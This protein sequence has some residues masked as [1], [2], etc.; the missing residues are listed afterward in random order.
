M[1]ETKE[2]IMIIP[3]EKILPNRFQPRIKFSEES[4]LNLADSIKEHGI[5]QP[6]IVRSIGDKY[7]IVAGERRYKATVLSGLKEIPALL[8]DINDKDSAEVALI[9]NVQRKDLSPIEEAISYKKILDMGYLTQSDLASKI[10]V[11]QS[12]VANK[13][14]L[15]NLCDDVQE[16]LLDEKISERHARS[17]LKINNEEVQAKFLKRILSKKLT[18]RALDD[19]IAFYIKNNKFKENEEIKN[20]SENNSSP[21]I[22]IK[23]TEEKISSSDKI[24]KIKE[25]LLE[26]NK[27]DNIEQKN[28]NKIDIK[29]DDKNS[30]FEDISIESF[31]DE[32]D[33]IDEK[34]EDDSNMNNN[35][36]NMNED[37]NYN[38]LKSSNGTQGKF[39]MTTD[40]EEEKPQEENSIF[41]FDN[42]NSG[43]NIFSDLMAPQGSKNLFRPGTTQ[44]SVIPTSTEQPQNDATPTNST[45]NVSSMFENLMGVSTTSTEEIDKDT[46]NKFMDPAYVDGEQ[47][48]LSSGN[49]DVNSNVFAKFLQT[50]DEPNKEEVSNSSESNNIFKNLLKKSNDTEEQNN[51]VVSEEKKEEPSNN[52][53]IFSNMFGLNKSE[54]KKEDVKTDNPTQE[55]ASVETESDPKPV[56]S[57]FEPQSLISTDEPKEE[58]KEESTVEEQGQEISTGDI[59][60]NTSNE[61]KPD[62][63]APMK[64]ESTN[65]I[66]L[67][68]SLADFKP[69]SSSTISETSVTPISNDLSSLSPMP[70]SIDT[71]KEESE[72]TEEPDSLNKSLTP[73]D[74]VE[75][76]E[77]KVEDKEEKEQETSEEELI[78]FNTTKPIFVTASSDNQVSSMPTSPII[79]V[80]EEQEEEEEVE[81][82]EQAPVV[83]NIDIED[84]EEEVAEDINNMIGNQPIIV[85]DYDKQYDPV[86]PD[87]AKEV[88]KI[89]FK[90]ILGL[91]R[92]LSETIE[93]CGYEIDTD[94][95]DLQDKYQVIFNIN[96]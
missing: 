10:G 5:L 64:E 51:T 4:I 45:P 2:N 79:N 80:P 35:L 92:E 19:E 91:I 46:F 11:S 8:Y 96:K 94:E 54:E 28:D 66:S 49:D 58:V 56:S 95:I 81:L 37:I 87:S 26:E 1:K 31:N 90:K 42:S 27:S 68:S 32:E 85:T 83:T 78:S 76:E 62:L 6:I 3:L 23:N 29:L 89:D 18:V 84:P 15:L 67:D 41:N 82:P 34:G 24:E 70:N 69:D 44:E 25:E 13:I 65:D 55:V 77:S 52:T 86:L 47:K 53:S 40:T 38:T 36:Q 14:R 60:G 63:L 22:E 20:L 73:D 57:I 12:A 88:E 59:F 33:T 72:S 93:K 21:I 75:K 71:T 9:E 30:I 74:T 17:L 48:D 43:G 7:E 50:D 61:N 39:F 16:A